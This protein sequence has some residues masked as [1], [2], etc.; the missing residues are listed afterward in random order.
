MGKVNIMFNE[1]ESQLSE[2]PGKSCEICTYS[3]E[4]K[5]NNEVDRNLIEASIVKALLFAGTSWHELGRTALTISCEHGSR[6]VV[7]AILQKNEGLVL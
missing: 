4:R 7:P 5:V 1:A 6:V 2:N 3:T